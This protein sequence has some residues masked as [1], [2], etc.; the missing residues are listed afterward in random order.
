[1]IGLLAIL[2]A[3]GAYVP[4]DPSYPAERFAFMLED[5][6]VAVLL[7]QAALRNRLRTPRDG[8]ICLDTDAAALATEPA[9][10]PPPMV[11]PDHLAYVIY[12]SGSTGKPKGVQIPHGALANVLAHF[13]DSLEL[14]PADTWLAVTT[15][16][17]DIAGLELWLPLI[18]GA[19]VILASRE[20]AVDGK[21]L[22][23]HLRTGRV[24]VMQATP[25]TWRMLLAEGW[26]APLAL[27][28]ICGG[29]PLSR[30][31]ADR[32]LERTAAL[33]NVYG[34]T[35]TTIWST[36]TRVTGTAGTVSI[37]RPIANTAAVV[38]DRR[39]QL[40]PCG[41]PGELYVGGAGL[42]RGYLGRSEL[43][44]QKFGPNPFSE[45]PGARLYR[46]GDLVRWRRDGGLDFLGRLDHQVKV[47][48]FRIEPGE[49]EARLRA[50]DAV[51]DTVVIAR[52]EGAGEQ[53]LVAYVVPAGEPV[54]SVT[55]LR[56][57]VAGALPDYMVP[58]A[59]VTLAAL[60]LTPSGKVDRGA[61]PA[62]DARRPALEQG[63]VAPRTEEEQ[64]L[65]RIWGDVLRLDK[66]GINDNFFDLGGHSLLATQIMARARDAFQTELPLPAIFEA[67]TI[68]GLAARAST[69][70]R[71]TAERPA[72]AIVPLS[73]EAY[74][75]TVPPEASFRVQW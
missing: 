72:A 40:L 41:V 75:V 14:G 67:P 15:L 55:D 52:D 7:T 66:I 73:R 29:E 39:G 70:K 4:L 26:N 60:P 36:S 43:T 49:I 61:L 20:E 9:T 32:L 10:P 54:P 2:K 63:Y 5:A 11:G 34:P 45:V 27:T 38:L 58:S 42:A 69:A 57:H 3:G 35:E 71:Q 16:S 21:R 47:R 30:D 17:F 12:T 44:A 18:T 37:G 19:T 65:A 22:L 8:V 13:G 59:F 48:G 53:R 74:T 31:L 68:A 24:S 46:T 6:Q 56:A 23:A 1:V 64:V 28:A 62:P 25:A 50:H 51:Q 33:W